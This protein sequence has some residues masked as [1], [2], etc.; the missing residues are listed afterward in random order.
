VTREQVRRLQENK[1]FS[2]AAAAGD[3]GFNPRRLE[4]GLAQE[5]ALLRQEGVL[6]VKSTG[7][8]PSNP[9]AD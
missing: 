2:H 4:E 1:A 7:W 6:P 3:F 9:A 5:I 8:L